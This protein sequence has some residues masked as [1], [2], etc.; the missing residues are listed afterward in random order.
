MEEFRI[1][2]FIQHLES[3]EEG[4]NRLPYS[5]VYGDE[6]RFLKKLI[7]EYFSRSRK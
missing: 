5:F 2:F 3:L 7:N 4:E 1:K 6:I